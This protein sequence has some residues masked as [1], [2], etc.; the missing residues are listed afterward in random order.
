MNVYT[1]VFENGESCKMYSHLFEM[2]KN[3]DRVKLI[4]NEFG[5]MIYEK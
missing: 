3:Q 5:E 2:A 1:V 4:F